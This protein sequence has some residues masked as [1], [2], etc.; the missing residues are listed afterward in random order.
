MLVK[1]LV[2][3]SE[4]ILLSKIFESIKEINTENKKNIKIIRTRSG[5]GR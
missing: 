5:N 3:T 2:D 1:K 4:N